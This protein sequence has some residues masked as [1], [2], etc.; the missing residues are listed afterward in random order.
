MCSSNITSKDLKKKKKKRC[1]RPSIILLNKRSFRLLL[2]H[3]SGSSAQKAIVV[4]LRLPR[5]KAER[6]S[7]ALLRFIEAVRRLFP[8]SVC[9]NASSWEHISELDYSRTMYGDP[10]ISSYVNWETTRRKEIS[11]SLFPGQKWQFVFTRSASCCF[12][13]IRCILAKNM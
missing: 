1:C 10:T 9:N 2:P 12:T 4:V 8:A 7:S 11:K 5:I 3:V 13:E 6:R